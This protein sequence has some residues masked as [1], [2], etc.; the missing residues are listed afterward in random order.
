MTILNEE[1][2]DYSYM[3]SRQSWYEAYVALAKTILQVF[4]K[5]SIVDVGCATGYLV[6]ELRKFGFEAFGVDGARAATQFWPQ[7]HRTYYLHMDVTDTSSQLPV[8][9]IV[10]SFELAEHIKGKDAL[11]LI[12]LLTSS[13]P[14]WVILTATPP[15]TAL[16]KSHVNEQP[17][18]YW[19]SLFETKSYSFDPLA[20][21]AFRSA[22]RKFGAVPFW[23]IQ[24]LMVF[25]SPLN[26]KNI[27][28]EEFLAQEKKCL[29]LEIQRL[30][31]IKSL[32]I[33]AFIESSR[34]MLSLL[35]KE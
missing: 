17:Y 10:C 34:N 5:T 9:E 31:F 26:K 2:Y 16:D 28:G 8:T 14:K 11:G 19:L 27:S 33:D 29:E 21:G 20:T 4:G 12:T 24:N 32:G 3:T 13:S 1:L 35:Q 23:Y 15:G 18:Q 30:H 7:N 25:R 6:E 22:L